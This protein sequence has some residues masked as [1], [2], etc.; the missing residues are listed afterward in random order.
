MLQLKCT[1]KVQTAL[2]LKA[3]QLHAIQTTD[4]LLGDWFVN[5]LTI[6]RSKTLLFVNEKTLLSFIT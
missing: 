5:L 3:D 4:T 2:K 6:D 1:G